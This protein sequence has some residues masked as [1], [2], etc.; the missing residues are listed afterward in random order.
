MQD[1]A[2]TSTFDIAATRHHPS[3]KTF[4]ALNSKNSVT[5]YQRT[6]LTQATN[7]IPSAKEKATYI[8]LP[9]YTSDVNYP[10]SDK[11]DPISPGRGSILRDENAQPVTRKPKKEMG[12]TIWNVRL[13]SWTQGG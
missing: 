10:K 7:H 2:S 5:K 8:A 13:A 1:F 12:Q 9:H 11:S 4:N 6:K 3:T